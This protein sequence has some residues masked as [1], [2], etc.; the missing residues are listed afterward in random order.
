[1]TIVETSIAVLYYNA[2]SLIPKPD[3]LHAITEVHNPDVICVV[4]TW[5]GEEISSA[6][7]SIPDYQ[8]LRLDRNRHGGGVL[9]YVRNNLV[10]NV[11]LCGPHNLELL[12]ISVSN[13]VSTFCIGTFYR[14]PSSPYIN[15][16]YFYTS[17]ASI[18]SSRFSNFVLLGDFNIHYED[19]HHP[20]YHKLQ[21]IVQSFSLTQVV[22][23][24]THTTISGAA[25]LIDLAFLSNPE[26]LLKCDVIRP[27]NN[28]SHRGAD[29]D[30]SGVFLQLKWR[31]GG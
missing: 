7:V 16:D 9:M 30:H 2:K 23:E 6:E 3:D 13:S 19:S 10:T 5:L 22:P 31:C 12:I 26:L 8:L 27:L 18:D 20:L 1:V 24:P 17:L 14:P 29:S 15:M 25:T 11:L 21:D 28:S 4:E